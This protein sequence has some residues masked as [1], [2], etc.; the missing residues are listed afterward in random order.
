MVRK[1]YNATNACWNFIQ[2]AY[3]VWMRAI[4]YSAAAMAV[5]LLGL[6]GVVLY[7]MWAGIPFE[8]L[9]SVSGLLLLGLLSAMSMIE[10]KSWLGIIVSIVV[11][12]TLGAGIWDWMI[13]Q[14]DVQ[15]AFDIRTPVMQIMLV[16]AGIGILVYSNWTLSRAFRSKP[17]K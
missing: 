16:S 3:A 6:Q 17:T 12:L 1:I 11:S 5:A 4:P 2:W 7:A 10:R 13:A 15:T 8:E 14:S 9:V